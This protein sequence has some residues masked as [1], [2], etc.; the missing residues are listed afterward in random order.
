MRSLKSLIICVCLITSLLQ[1][2]FG[3]A[4][5]PDKSKST[6]VPMRGICA[7]GCLELER[8]QLT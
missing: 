6:T 2:I 3:A 8:R 1:T 5:T 7:T 4:A